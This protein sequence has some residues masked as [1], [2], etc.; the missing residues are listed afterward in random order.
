MIGMDIASVGVYEGRTAEQ[1]SWW[2]GVFRSA[3]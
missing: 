2:S 1:V 3:G